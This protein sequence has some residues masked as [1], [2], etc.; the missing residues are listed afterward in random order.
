MK[1]KDLFDTQKTLARD[2]LE[3]YEYPWEVLPDIAKIIEALKDYLPFE[4]KE[5]KKDVFVHESAIINRACEINGPCIIGKG[6]EIRPGAYIRGN[7]I[8]G[9]N[10]V[11]GNSTEIKNSILFNGVQVPHYNYV[12]DSILGYKAHLGAGAV[13]SNVKSDKSIVSSFDENGN[14]VNTGLKKCGGFLGDFAEIG[15]HSVIT[16]GAIVGR[17]SNVYPLSLVRGAVPPHSIL[18]TGNIIV[19]KS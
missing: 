19:N 14:R 17:G 15:C 18:K 10:C 5:V 4:Y 2:F 16:P 9:E 13:I 7:A 11:I 8:I 12:G 6:C 3:N 1:I